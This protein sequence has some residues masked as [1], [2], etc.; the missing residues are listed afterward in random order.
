METTLYYR[1]EENNSD[2]FYRARLDLIAA[3]V[4]FTW[5]RRGTVGQSKTETFG[6][7]AW[8][9]EEAYRSKLAEKRAK[10]YQ[11]D[12]RD[13]SGARRCCITGCTVTAESPSAY[14]SRHRSAAGISPPNPVPFHRPTGSP[15]PSFDPPQVR[16]NYRVPARPLQRTAVPE[17]PTP[18][19]APIMLFGGR[20]IIKA[21]RSL[22]KKEDTNP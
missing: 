16:S 2:K 4:T 8:R 12:Y 20:R 10:G 6:G 5:G 3:T 15:P 22:Q 19:P 17:P 21:N 14:C 7:A 18:E 9:A 1:D 13:V 11:E